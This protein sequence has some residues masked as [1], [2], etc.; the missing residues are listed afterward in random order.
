M[1]GLSIYQCIGVTVHAAKTEK[2]QYEKCFKKTM[3]N[4]W[5]KR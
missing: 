3:C 4:L 5:L 2:P 1:Q